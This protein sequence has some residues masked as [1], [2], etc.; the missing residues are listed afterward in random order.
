MAR[1]YYSILVVG[2]NSSLDRLALWPHS[3]MRLIIGSLVLVFGVWFLSYN[4]AIPFALV[5]N[6]YGMMVIVLTVSGVIVATSSLRVFI[7]GY[8]TLFSSKKTICDDERKN[9][10]NL[11]K[12]LSKAVIITSSVAFLLILIF[13]ATELFNNPD[14]RHVLFAVCVGINQIIC[15]L[16]VALV[17]FELPAYSIS[18][19]HLH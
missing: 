14:N 13:S 5:P 9:M 10:V 11:F 3:F 8:R 7:R 17:F 4:W 15:G 12:L 19:L 18:K 6:P 1:L 16:L 2:H